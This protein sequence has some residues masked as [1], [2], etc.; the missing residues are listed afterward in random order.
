MA[1]ELRSPPAGASASG[2]VGPV[3]ISSERA[4]SPS[5]PD[6]PASGARAAFAASIVLIV[7]YAALDVVVQLLPPHYSAIVQP[8]SDLAVGPY[9]YIMTANFVVRGVLSAL[10]LYGLWF[11]TDLARRTRAPFALMGVWAAGAFVLAA[12]PT[13]VPAT[14]VSAHGAV[15]LVT[16]AIAFFAAGLGALLFSLQF[17][18]EPKLAGAREPALALGALAFLF[19]LLELFGPGAFPRIDARYDGL[20]ERIFLGLVLAW[21]A[22]VGAAYLAATTRRESRTPPTAPA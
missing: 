17:G 7:L 13:D 1:T 4:A 16:A 6:P 2:P 12:F 5:S 11:G 8:E 19:A 14:P 3:P 9:G 18:G 10:F 21:M 20:L 15:H 22:W